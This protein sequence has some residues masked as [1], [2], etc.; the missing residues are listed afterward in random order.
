MTVNVNQQTTIKFCSLFSAP[1]VDFLRRL[2]NEIGLKIQVHYPLSIEK[3]IIILSWIGSE[4]EADS[5]LVN[6][7]LRVIEKHS[8]EI[9]LSADIDANGKIF[10]RTENIKSVGLQYLGA[11]RT[12]KKN[13]ILIKRTIHVA[14]LPNEEIFGPDEMR[15]FM[16]SEGFKNLNI[17]FALDEGKKREKEIKTIINLFISG[18]ASTS[19]VFHVFY[20]E[21]IYWRKLLNICL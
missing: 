11:I 13:K 8:N 10:A 2:S 20:G 9:S 4:P 21:R 3:P 5:I 18:I 6:S 1:Y 19:D 16:S 17:G 15:F 12:L 14:F 7:H